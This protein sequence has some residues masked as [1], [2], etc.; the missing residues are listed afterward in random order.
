[1]QA[2]SQM[3]KPRLVTKELTQGPQLV[4]FRAGAAFQTSLTSSH[5]LLPLQRAA[6]SVTHIRSCLETS[7]F[8]STCDQ[9]FPALRVCHISQQA[10]GGPRAWVNEP[11]TCSTAKLGYHRVA[12]PT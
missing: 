3:R 9:I 7:G 6:S 11:F 10:A 12:R 4:G 1:M 5:G 8:L 2:L